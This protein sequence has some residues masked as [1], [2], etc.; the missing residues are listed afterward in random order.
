MKRLSI[1]PVL[2]FLLVLMSETSW[3]DERTRDSLSSYRSIVGISVNAIDFDV[4]NKDSTSSN[5]TLSEDFSYSPFISIESPY[6][7]FGD[8]N[9]GGLME[10]S[11]SSF[12]LKQQLI[13][14]ELS[15]LGTSVKGYYTFVTPTLFYSFNGV[16]SYNNNQML[17]AGLGVGFGYLNASG[18]V[19]FTE[20]TQELHNIDINGTALA[21][22]LFLDYRTGDFVTRI[23]GGLTSH[24]KDNYDY[25]A[26]GFTWSFGY[27]FGL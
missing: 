3:S 7:F 8:S 4:Y 23:S 21:I 27:V 11:L 9:W 19:I 17:I 13:D 16:S 12:N 18:E 25:D 24:T 15:D 5:G 26:F 10:Y 2:F 1:N 22:S 20:T 14:N 6:K